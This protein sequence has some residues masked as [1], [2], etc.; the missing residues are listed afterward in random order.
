MSL[1]TLNISIINQ[2]IYT[3]IISKIHHLLLNHPNITDFLIEGLL[4]LVDYA[5]IF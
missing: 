3:Y 5:N 2:F 1:A 4:M